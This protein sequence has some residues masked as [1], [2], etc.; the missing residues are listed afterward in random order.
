MESTPNRTVNQFGL[1]LHK[2]KEVLDSRV[3][4]TFNKVITHFKNLKMYCYTKSF[5]FAIK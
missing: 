2:K 5:G 3:A 1:L 4:H